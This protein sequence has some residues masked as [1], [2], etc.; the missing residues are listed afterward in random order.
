MTAQRV[1]QGAHPAP[2]PGVGRCMATVKLD[3]LLGYYRRG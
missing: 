3:E 1:S 2:H